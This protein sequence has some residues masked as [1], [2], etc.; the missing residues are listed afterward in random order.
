MTPKGGIGLA[1]YTGISDDQPWETHGSW[2]KSHRYTMV[3]VWIDNWRLLGDRDF[4][5]IP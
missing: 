1:H 2:S 3:A 5:A 4:L